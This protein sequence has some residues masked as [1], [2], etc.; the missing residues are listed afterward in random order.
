MGLARLD[1][2]DCAAGF[3]PGR[4]AA[5]DMRHRP[6][7]HLLRNLGGKRRTP[8]AG[9]VKHEFL[10]FLKDR[11]G[12]GARRIDP[13]LEHAAWAMEC[14]GDPSFTLDLA[15]IAQVDD[16]GIGQIGAAARKHSCRFGGGDR[17]D[18]GIGLV[19]HRLVT[20]NDGLGHVRS[21]LAFD[22]SNC[23]D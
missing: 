4:E 21:L 18:R 19:E 3:T 11:L 15:R 6:Q 12:I 14:A 13:E 7:A 22:F 17:L 2:F 23:R 5:T 1:G 8:A 16:D 9:T 20:A 10:V